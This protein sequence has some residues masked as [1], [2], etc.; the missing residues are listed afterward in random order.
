MLVPPDELPSLNLL[1]VK[2]HSLHQLPPLWGPS[3][4]KQED[5]HDYI[6]SLLYSLPGEDQILELKAEPGRAIAKAGAEP[7]EPENA[8]QGQETKEG[9][10]KVE[11][12]EEDDETFEIQRTE[13]KVFARNEKTDARIVFDHQHRGVIRGSATSNLKKM[14][15]SRNALSIDLRRQLRSGEDYVYAKKYHG[16]VYVDC[17]K[18]LVPGETKVVCRCAVQPADDY[19]RPTPE[20][21]EACPPPGGEPEEDEDANPYL[22]A[23]TYLLLEIELLNPLFEKPKPPPPVL[24]KVGD[25]LPTRPPVDVVEKPLS[26]ADQFGDD[27]KEIIYQLADE[28]HEMFLG[29]VSSNISAEGMEA[30]RQQAIFHLNSSGKYYDYKERLKKSIVRLIHEKFHKS[31]LDATSEEG[32]K[33][34]SQL[35]VYLQELM[36][37]NLNKVFA[38]PKKISAVERSEEAKKKYLREQMRLAIEA[39]MNQDLHLAASHLNQRIITDASDAVLWFDYGTFCIRAGMPEKAEEC[40]REA[41]MLDP[42]HIQALMSYGVLLCTMNRYADAETYFKAATDYSPDNVLCW[43][44]LMLFYDMESRDLE[45]R[46]ALKK[47]MTLDKAAGTGKKS[48]YIRAGL[49]ASE[50]HAVQLVERAAAQDLVKNGPSQEFEI[51]LA[52]TYLSVRQLERVKEMLLPPDG[53]LGKDKRHAVAM[54]LLGHALFLEGRWDTLSC[55]KPASSS[56]KEVMSFYEKAM[57][58][59]SPNLEPLQYLR[60]CRLYLWTGKFYEAKDVAIKA[61]KLLPSASSWLALG[62]ACYKQNELGQAEEAL[63]EANILD[64]SNPQV[65]GMLSVIAMEAGKPD[66]SELALQQALK[67]GLSTSETFP[68]GTFIL[69]QMARLQVKAGIFS[70]ASSTLRRAL[71]T[72]N[73][74]A[75]HLLLAQTCLGENDLPAAAEACRQVLEH[76]VQPSEA[77]RKDALTQLVAIYKRLKQPALVDKYSHMLKKVG[78]VAE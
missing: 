27:V 66:E 55:D 77:E 22:L 52:K 76:E 46:T 38:P 31:G 21:L 2:L 73:R 12:E 48:A 6:Y 41:L 71:E 13:S 67:L 75:L 7:A 49:F 45:R 25:L 14:L 18:L 19:A 8:E 3:E 57:G 20:E 78:A 34:I 11:K 54:T 50:L 72:S 43:C 42:R 51:L 10:E 37:S 28:Y 62:L 17:D 30:R 63:C 15:S 4:D 32:K 40:L 47:V 61:C 24:P 16:V 65:W 64:P 74:A 68:V 69:E 44:M 70:L 35:Y 9:G 39:E 29:E 26:A 58:Q 56:G 5:A 60:L 36:N 1:S 53:I 59:R 23:E 33:F